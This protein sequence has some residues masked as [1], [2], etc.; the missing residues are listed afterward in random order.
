MAKQSFLTELETY[1]ADIRMRSSIEKLDKVNLVMDDL[2]KSD[3]LFGVETGFQPFSHVPAEENQ[4]SRIPTQLRQILNDVEPELQ[5]L[6][7][8]VFDEASRQEYLDINELKLS[9][10]EAK[11][12][13]YLD[14]KMS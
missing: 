9:L 5:N 7:N 14:K 8:P 2:G 10:F 4:N 11:W 13:W 3:P 1:L 6:F 12:K